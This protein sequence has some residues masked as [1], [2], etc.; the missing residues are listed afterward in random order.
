[1]LDLYYLLHPFH[2]TVCVEHSELGLMP[3]EKKTISHG[4][5]PTLT[6]NEDL[7]HMNPMKT[8]P[9]SLFDIG[10][11]LNPM[12]PTLWL[13]HS[14]SLPPPKIVEASKSHSQFGLGRIN[15]VYHN[16]ILNTF[17]SKFRG[18]RA[19][20]GLKVNNES[21]GKVVV[22][23]GAGF[24][25]SEV[26]SLLRRKGYDV[27]IISRHKFDAR[28]ITWDDIRFQ[29]IPERTVAVVNLAG[30]NM[31]EPLKRWNPAFKELIRESR[32]Q[33]ARC[34]KEA[35]I[36]KHKAGME[37]PEVYV[38]ITGVGIYPPGDNDVIYDED[39]KV[40]ESDGGFMSR[41][42]M[43]WEEAAK[44]PP[45]VATRNVFVRSGV[46]LGR[47]GGMIKQI[48]LPF[49]MGTGGRMGS[50]EQNMPWI[51]VKDVSGIIVH[52]IENKKVAGVL[53]GV[54][55]QI[56]TNQEFVNAFA[57][58]LHRPA[59]IPL[60]DF[61]W[62]LVFGEERAEVITKGV[63]VLPKRTVDDAE[64]K[65]RYPT[66]VEACQE[67]SHFFYNDPDSETVAK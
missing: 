27:V 58:A 23:G 36:N 22:G 52:S 30:Q 28:V 29:G 13:E 67:F 63:T 60:P 9:S 8:D 24:V 65:F 66:I 38:Q 33:T 40:Q 17:Y 59:L 34:L 50:G 32:I 11:L 42:V 51:H 44:L 54:T 20:E 19:E 6:D 64:Y 37:V 4:N 3:L 31:L 46:V 25:G 12:H 62:N 48:F 7:N 41:L 57:S 10:S 35:I 5:K 49:F 14:Q 18:I 53:N 15:Q 1:M 47:N 26:C 43:D 55:P 16:L 45:E 39:S 56:I 21:K 2:P 61:V